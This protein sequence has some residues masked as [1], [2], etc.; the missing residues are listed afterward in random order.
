MQPTHKKN[1]ALP[2]FLSAL[3]FTS[4]SVSETS[5]REETSALKPIITEITENIT[6]QTVTAF[7]E[8]TAAETVQEFVSHADK[9]VTFSGDT[10]STEITQADFENCK[11]ALEADGAFILPDKRITAYDIDYDGKDEMIALYGFY[12]FIFEKNGED[13]TESHRISAVLS[14]T[15]CIDSLDLKTYSDG[16]EKY[17]YFSFHYDNNMICDV[18]ASFKYDKE[19]DSYSCEYIISWGKI[20]YGDPSNEF[21]HAFFRKGWNYMDRAA[22]PYDSDI[23]QEEFLEIYNRYEGLPPWDAYI[24]EYDLIESISVGDTA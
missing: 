17:P 20:E 10:S 2:L 8:V 7:E 3:L 6:R 13:I 19:S 11:K 24:A 21:N 22:G 23:S 18:L 4:C 12:F 9:T 14:E 15:G 5:R 1:K 16:E